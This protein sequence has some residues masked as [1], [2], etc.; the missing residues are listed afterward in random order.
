MHNCDSTIKASRNLQLENNNDFYNQNIINNLLL[1]NIL[2]CN[3]IR[4][5]HEFKR[6]THLF[7]FMSKTVVDPRGVQARASPLC[8]N[9]FIFMQFSA[10]FF[11]KIIGWRIPWGVGAPLWEILDP[12]QKNSHWPK[13]NAK[14]YCFIVYLILSKCNIIWIIQN[15]ILSQSRP[16]LRSHFFFL[17]NTFLCARL[18]S[19]NLTD[20]KMYKL[21]EAFSKHY[22]FIIMWTVK[23]QRNL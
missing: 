21:V 9:S 18:L 11:F 16:K 13:T 22:L 5:Q 12:P 20:R 19:L 4:C 6:V 2:K 15:K 8:P 3:T 14:M 1:Y 10:I 17:V 23:W 7:Y